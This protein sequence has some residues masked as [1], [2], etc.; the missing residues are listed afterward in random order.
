VRRRSHRYSYLDGDTSF[1]GRIFPSLAALLVLTTSIFMAL[2][3]FI[4]NPAR[5]QEYSGG[6][7]VLKLAYFGSQQDAVFTEV[8]RPWAEAINTDGA[9]LIRIDTH[10]G[11]D[12]GRNPRLQLKLVETGKAHIVWHQPEYTPG[13]FPDNEV[14]ELPATT[15]NAQEASVVFRRLYERDLL[16]G[17]ED[18]Y[19][20]LL[21]A[22]QPY[23][24]HT[25]KR[26][27]AIADFKGMKLRADGAIA[28]AAMR[29][30]G[31]VPV[32]MP[33]AAVAENLNGG[34]LAGATG[35][36]CMLF[37][38]RI[39][40]AAT[41]HYM[42]PL[43]AAPVM[44]VMDKKT[45]GALPKRA[46]DIIRKHSGE[47]L[48]KRFAQVHLAR[49]RVRLSQAQKMDGHDFFFPD[50]AAQS[51]WDRA[52]K[53]VIEDWVKKHPKGEELYAALTQELDRYR[54]Y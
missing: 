47:N 53:P 27:A 16:R 45:F 12:L 2:F 33:V 29:A 38:H 18:F 17:Y 40:E 13:R 8:I 11:G 10:P 35:E 54:G 26:V 49:Q 14:I 31:A 37:E 4:S 48:T 7:A 9:G 32:G 51:A 24:I 20:P 19:V 41:H 25:T 22:T 3:L 42:A 28:G 21:A 39:V 43:G 23:T 6:A 52:M 46:Q 5:A 30:L 1:F 44:M 50:G 36:W 34:V 15:N